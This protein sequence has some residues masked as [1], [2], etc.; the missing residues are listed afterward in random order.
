MKLIFRN[1]FSIIK[2]YKIAWIMN[3]LGIAIALCALMFVGMQIFYEHDFEKCNTKADRIFRLNRNATVYPFNIIIPRGMVECAGNCSP[4][5]E[6][7]TDILDVF[8]SYYITIETNG[9]KRGFYQKVIGADPGITKIFDFKFI[10]GDENCLENP[11]YAIIS[12][13][14]ALKIF[15]S[16]DI[17]GQQ[18]NV[19]QTWRMYDSTLIVGAVYKDF[20]TNTQVRNEIYYKLNDDFKDD[21]KNSNDVCWLLLDNPNSKSEIENIIN[22][23]LKEITDYDLQM[24]LSPIKDVYYLNESGDGMMMKSGDFKNT[25]L[26]GIISL[27]VL[28]ISIINHTNF[29]I[30]LIPKRIKSINTQKVLGSDIKTLRKQLFIEN[31]FTGIASWIVALIL[32]KLL[33]G[34]W[35]TTFLTPTDLSISNNIVICLY[36]LGISILMSIISGIYPIIKLTSINP[37][38]AIKGNYGNSNEGRKLR[39]SLL[40][41]QYFS[42]FAFMIISI[43]VWIQNNYMKN[44]N[45]TLN[46]NQIA[47]FK[48]NQIIAN[49]KDLI[50]DK[51][52][53]HTC[54]ENVAFSNQKLGASDMYQTTTMTDKETNGNISFNLI[55]CSEEIVDVFDI[56]I[57]EGENYKHGSNH[58]YIMTKN[59]FTKMKINLHEDL[60]D[61]D[62][63]IGIIDDG[64]KIN[65]Q[66]NITMD[67]CF[68]TV[69]AW[70]YNFAYVKL[71]KGANVS[72]CINYIKET[73]EEIAPGSPVD[74]EFYDQIFNQLYKNE[75]NMSHL[76]AFLS[77]IAI[78][79]SIIGIFGM[80]I[81]DNEYKRK[82]IALRKVLGASVEEILKIANIKYLKMVIVSFIASVPVAIVIIS[83]WQESFIE[84]ANI[85]W[86]I[87]ALILL[88]M[89]I[90]TILIITT[91]TLKTA[92][93]NPIESLKSE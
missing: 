20:P 74:I 75:V 7:Y 72:D 32:V 37:A 15:G 35:V 50:V 88:S 66:R 1:L 39:N 52:K 65:S 55:D 17:I 33:N 61:N 67:L 9:K 60:G 38:I 91:Q 83:K 29:S 8:D 28:I 24:S 56:K 25:L 3:F 30:A 19:N 79:I 4:K 82:E 42:A 58:E 73:V 21:Y 16:T 80:I 76:T 85:P 63:C 18:I 87:F 89:T 10:N 92:K 31:I 40:I 46:N 23:K 36:V 45:E 57:I 93:E 11:K 22:Q 14:T 5:I 48:S 54:I 44:S 64:I 47:V 84:K 41:I 62:F 26:L 78:L 13:N 71:S 6:A 34:T 51:L 53:E 86:W 2:R 43:S 81:F 77:I 49:K 68:R 70:G 27:I 59:L 12:E 90:I 69:G